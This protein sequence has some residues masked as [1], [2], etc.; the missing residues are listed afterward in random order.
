MEYCAAIAAQ[1]WHEGSAFVF[2]SG[3]LFASMYNALSLHKCASLL[4][5]L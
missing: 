2:N 5:N 1:L 4:R 3:A